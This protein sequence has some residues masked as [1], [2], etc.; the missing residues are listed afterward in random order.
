MKLKEGEREFE[1]EKVWP[2]FIYHSNSIRR[3][4]W[5]SFSHLSCSLYT[6]KTPRRNFK[7]N[8]KRE[9]CRANYHREQMDFLLAS[10]LY[11]A[12]LGSLICVFNAARL[13]TVLYS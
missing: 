10:V 7:G 6:L 8:L 11:N 3:A 2:Y 4:V 13:F 5:S 12:S 1:T 9:F